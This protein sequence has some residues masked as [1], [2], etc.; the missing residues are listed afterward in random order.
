MRSDQW[1]RPVDLG[2]AVGISPSQ[3]R[4]YEQVGFIPA[5]ARSVTGYRRYTQAHVDALRVARCLIAGY[6]WKHARDV[7][8]AVHADDVATALAL[9]DS[10][11]A[12]L[13]TQ[14]A[15]VDETLTALDRIGP[16]EPHGST[17]QLI[18][19]GDAARIVGAR[20]SALRFWEGQ[21]LVSPVRDNGGGIRYY[22]AEQIQRLQIVTQ[23]RAAGYRFGAIRPVLADLARNQP[24]K[25]RAA[26]EERRRA[27]TR[28]SMR[29][30]R[31]T[32]ELQQYLR[33]Y[34]QQ[35]VDDVQSATGPDLGP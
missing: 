22:D 29:A 5:A 23:L 2:R 3:V 21:G 12:R 30:M 9:V 10:A 24:A 11:H 32:S 6:G 7:M 27:I 20:P 19:I 34:K 15:Q 14:R 26:L 4:T 13:S 17:R 16:P 28:A 8:S 18:R 25:V 1:F 31:A 35:A 33:G